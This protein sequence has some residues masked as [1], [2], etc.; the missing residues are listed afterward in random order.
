MAFPTLTAALAVVTLAAAVPASAQVLEGPARVI[1]GDTVV[2][3]DTHIR[4]HGSDSP[5]SGQTCTNAAG[6]PYACGAVATEALRG[7]IGNQPLRCVGTGLDRYGRTIA[8]CA[9]PNGVDPERWMVRNGLSTAYRHFSM[10]YA[11]DEDAARG[12]RRGL[13]TGSFESPYDWR[14][15]HSHYGYSN[16]YSFEYKAPHY[17]YAPYGGF[18]VR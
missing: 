16:P 8:S 4:F 9:L 17:G 6:Q 12:E 7:L 18:R 3:G 14:R 2:I 5:E 13:W 15:A 10:A 1:D 11:A